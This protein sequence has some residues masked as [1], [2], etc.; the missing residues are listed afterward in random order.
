MKLTNKNFGQG[1][2]GA[3]LFYPADEKD[4]KLF[5]HC[6]SGHVAVSLAFLDAYKPVFNNHGIAIEVGIGT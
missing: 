4:V 6:T 2:H 3:N 1:W 5:M